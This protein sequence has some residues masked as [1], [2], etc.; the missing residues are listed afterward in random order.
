MPIHPRAATL[1][2]K[3]ASQPVKLSMRNEDE[4]MAAV[5]EGLAPGASVLVTRLDGIKPGSSV[6]LATATKG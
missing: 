6:K 3:V 2:V 5:S 1:A 4:G